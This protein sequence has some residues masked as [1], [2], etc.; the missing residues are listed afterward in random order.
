MSKSRC[1][2]AEC[3]Q[4]TS[5]Q[6]RQAVMYLK[7]LFFPLQLGCDRLHRVDGHDGCSNALFSA[8]NRT[9]WSKFQ[10]SSCDTAKQNS[11][12]S[13]KTGNYSDADSG[14]RGCFLSLS[15]SSAFRQEAQSLLLCTVRWRQLNRG[16]RLDQLSAFVDHHPESKSNTKSIHRSAAVFRPSVLRCP[17]GSFAQLWRHFGRYNTR[18]QNH[19]DCLCTNSTHWICSLYLNQLNFLLVWQRGR[20]W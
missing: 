11:R 19:K 7:A 6:S 1:R 9:S 3:I 20:R 14:P 4:A 8:F 2:S 5:M 12:P 10:L 15:L 17:A 18:C 16:L 13:S